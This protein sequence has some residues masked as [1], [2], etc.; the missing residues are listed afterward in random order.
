MVK[1]V[2]WLPSKCKPSTEK[3]ANV[4]CFEGIVSLV[5]GERILGSEKRKQERREDKVLVLYKST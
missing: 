2:E 5:L 1:V 3:K 4:G